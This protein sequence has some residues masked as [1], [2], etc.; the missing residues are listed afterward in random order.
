MDPLPHQHLGLWSGTPIRFGIKVW[1]PSL[2]NNIWEYDLASSPSAFWIMIW[3]PLLP[4]AFY[5]SWW[6]LWLVIFYLGE[7]EP[8]SDQLKSFTGRNIWGHKCKLV[9]NM[10]WEQRNCNSCIFDHSYT[11]KKRRD[12]DKHL[13]INYYIILYCLVFLWNIWSKYTR[14]NSTYSASSTENKWL[15]VCY[16]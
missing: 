14:Q 5:V 11:A 6:C 15:K 13:E 2:P 7:S 3:N 8:K 1:Y 10:D 9:C 16:H 12:M 4:S